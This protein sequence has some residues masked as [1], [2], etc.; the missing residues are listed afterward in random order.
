MVLAAA[1]LLRLSSGDVPGPAATETSN[2]MFHLREP[3]S[4]IATQIEKK[5]TFGFPL[6]WEVLS[7]HGHGLGE[8]PLTGAPP[9]GEEQA[10]RT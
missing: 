1:A 2:V 3:C 7:L 10:D 9:S 4:R 5:N 6:G 8:V